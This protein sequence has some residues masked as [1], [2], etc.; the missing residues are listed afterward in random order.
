MKNNAISNYLSEA[1]QELTKVSWPTKNQAV[2]LT[3]IVM[4]FCL[5]TGVLLGAL[6]FVLSEIFTYIITNA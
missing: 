6:D 3:I 4:V 5:I 1:M 2:R